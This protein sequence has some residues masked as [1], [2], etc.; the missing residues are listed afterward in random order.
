MS[1][2]L[3]ALL[4][5]DK[6]VD[7]DLEKLVGELKK[8]QRIPCDEKNFKFAEMLATLEANFRVASYYH[9]LIPNRPF[10]HA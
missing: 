9:P 3:I 7:A 6:K 8:V 2:E 5:K 1:E 4:R 10:H